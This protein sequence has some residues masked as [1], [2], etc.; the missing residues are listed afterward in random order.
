MTLPPTVEPK[1]ASALTPTSATLNATVN[2][3]GGE[4]SECK[5]EY[6]TTTAYGESA[7]CTPSPGSGTSP[8]AVSAAI[9]GLTGNSEYHFRV[10]ATNP[11]GTSKGADETFTTQAI[12][13]PT[14]SSISPTSGPATGG[15]AVT[16][17]GTGFVAPAT[18]TIGSAAT[19][20]DVVTET[21]IKATTPAG[22]G[23]HE[24]VVTDEG[25]VSTVGPT[26]TYIP[27]PPW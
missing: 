9:T 4:V 26:F 16:I 19:G 18:V 13:S 17:K 7:P 1:A 24:V 15:T 8:V 3:E 23:T 25:G 11:G 12:P 21:E 10:S 14:V 5:F 6:G 27:A 22:S 20:V 2:P